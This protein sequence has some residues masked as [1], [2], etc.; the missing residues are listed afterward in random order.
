MKRFYCYSSNRFID[1]HDSSQS[2]P[3]LCAGPASSG[4]ASLS[5]SKLTIATSIAPGN[6][7][8][9]S[10]AIESWIKLGL[11]VVSINCAEEIDTLQQSFP[12]VKFIPA[13]RDGREIFGKP[14]IYF[15]DFLEYFKEAGSE[16][17]GIVNSDIHLV[18][19]EEI[20]SFIKKEAKNCL[21]Y[22]SRIEVD[23]LYVLDGEFY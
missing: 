23:S 13:K 22:G 20:I 5:G 12:D 15:D 19:D 16:F 4:S 11:N 18:G 1:E 7:D 2:S 3:Q 17:C 6:I 9:Q 10:K 8:R 14:V 21:V